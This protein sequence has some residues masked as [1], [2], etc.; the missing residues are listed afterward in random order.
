[1]VVS[2]TAQGNG[3]RKRFCGGACRKAAWDE[4]RRQQQTPTGLRIAAV[5]RHAT[6]DGV[7][8]GVRVGP[9]QLDRPARFAFADPPYPGLSTLYPE[10]YEV[11]HGPLVQMLCQEWPDGW[12]LATSADALGD[13]LRICPPG[14]R[15]CAWLHQHR[16]HG[17]TPNAWDPLIVCGGRRIAGNGVPNAVHVRAGNAWDLP[18]AKP[19]L[20]HQWAMALLGATPADDWTDLYPGSGSGPR[21][22]ASY[23]GVSEVVSGLRAPYLREA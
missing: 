4:R 8:A 10:G 16:P 20:Y 11:E 6:A 2:P 21:A 3:A 22:W 15:V 18:G 12:A 1:M 9:A 5:G 7:A 23:R 17:P 13:V 14:V 19:R